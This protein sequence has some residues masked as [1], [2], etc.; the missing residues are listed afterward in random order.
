M[1]E[2][3]DPYRKWLGIPEQE[4]PPN[5]YRLLGIELFESDADVISNAADGRMAQLKNYQAGK[6]SA[7]SQKLLNEI[8]T[9]KV[10]LLHPARKAEYDR[11]LG[12]RSEGKPEDTEISGEA[13]MEIAGISSFSSARTSAPTHRAGL[14]QSR[15]FMP[16]LM[17]GGAVLFIVFLAF[18]T[19]EDAHGVAAKQ[20]PSAPPLLQPNVSAPAKPEPAKP[21]TAPEKSSPATEAKEQEKS[22]KEREPA[23]LT[24]KEP[25]KSE[26]PAFEPPVVK[27]LEPA[28]PA[29]SEAEKKPGKL[30]V[31]DEAKQKAAEAKIRE[32]FGQEL[33][34][35]KTADQ[36]LGLASKLLK[37]GIDTDDDSDARF[38]LLRMACNLAAEAGELGEAFRTVDTLA[39]SYEFN[40]LNVKVDLLAKAVEANRSGGKADVHAKSLL[41][42]AMTILEEALAVDNFEAASR[43]IKTAT[44]AARAAKDPQLL[45]ETAARVREVEKL[46]SKFA[47][48]EKAIASL[49]DKPDDA[50]AN[51]VAGQWYCFSKGDWAKGLPLLQKGA[52]EKLAKLAGQD[53]SQPKKPK[54]QTALADGWWDL[55]DSEQGQAKSVLQARA[56]HWYEAALPKLSGLDKLKV[57]KRLESLTASTD[58][59][60]KAPASTSK[61]RGF[62]ENGNIALAGSGTTVVGPKNGLTLFDGKIVSQANMSTFASSNYPCEWTITFP[63]IYRLQAISFLLHD[64]DKQRFYRYRV[65]VSAD[66]KK[67]R[68]L[69]DRSQG[70]WRGWQRI[71]LPPTPVK[72]VKLIGLYNSANASFVVVEF[73]AYCNIPRNR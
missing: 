47:A 13:M 5:H 38:V 12:E 44:A 2:S 36:K 70:E 54:E 30:P 46:K 41:S 43:I 20:A 34:A 31:P 16:L 35:A 61:V 4:R 71:T 51:L 60:E 67:F 63:K 64:Q 55:A 66:G 7:Y 72:A 56:V 48:V 25:A 52:D 32:I 8:A 65:Q 23:Q 73:E 27:P 29:E 45:R 33:S 18:W 11:Q 3:F 28:A 37:Q 57:E 68:D 14:K 17:T 1:P 6:Y 9:A 69:V 24:V 15:W 42:A 62:V 40:P 22:T 49:K 58:L 50:D 19:R 21:A 39:E 53:L 59:E 10:C 26:E